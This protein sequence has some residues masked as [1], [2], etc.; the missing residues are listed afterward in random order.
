MKKW[1]NL[2]IPTIGLIMSSPMFADVDSS[3]PYIL[4]NSV[5][6]NT[7]SRLKDNKDR[8]QANS[9]LLY[10]V[11]EEELMPYIN[12]RYAAMKVLASQ[13]REATKEERD[14]FTEAFYGYMVESYVHILRGYTDQELKVEPIKAVDLKQRIVSVRVEIMDSVRPPIRFDFILRR[15]GKTHHWQVFDLQIEGVS[16]LD[17]KA[18]EWSAKL[19]KNGIKAVAK[20]LELRLKSPNNKGNKVEGE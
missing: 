9:D 12:V 13:A 15:N 10:V 6:Q 4:V 18:G 1:L 17:V 19:R 7:F 2:C 8:Y 14:L 5:A 11:V 16:I 20:E 3:N